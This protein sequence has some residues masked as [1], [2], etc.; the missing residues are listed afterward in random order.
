MITVFI[1]KLEHLN[2]EEEQNVIN[3]LSQRA[4]ARLNKKR[5]EALRLASLCALSLLTDTQRAD[6][7]YTESGRP[8]FATLD[9]D[10]SISHSKERASIAISAS[11]NELVGIDIEDNSSLPGSLTRF[12]AENERRAVENGESPIAIWTKKEALFKHLKNDDI[13][14]ISLD[15]AASDVKFTSVQMDNSILTVCTSQDTEIEIIQK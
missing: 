4:L 1:R 14:F 8:F 10:V 7:D 5:N 3:S 6:L 12:F 15:S 13:P 11:K 2:K 9:A